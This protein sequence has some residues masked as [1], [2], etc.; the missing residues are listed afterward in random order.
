MSFFSGNAS[1]HAVCTSIIHHPM[2]D[3]SGVR[4][5]FDDASRLAV[6]AFPANLIK[7]MVLSR[8]AVPACYVLADH[9]RIYVGETGNIGRRLTDHAADPAKAFAREVFI[10]MGHEPAWLDK[11]AAIYLQHRLTVVADGAA[12]V[13]VVKGVSPQVLELPGYRRASYDRFFGDSLRLLYDAGCR[14]FQSNMAS[15]IR[16]Q[17]LNNPSAQWPEPDDCAPMEIGVIASPPIG[18]ELELTYSDLWAR[19]FP[20][21]EGFVVMAGSEMRSLINAS[22]TP[23]VHARRAELVAAGALA[24]IPGVHDRSRLKVAV[25]FPS[26]AIAAKVLAGAHVDSSKW[27]LPRYPQPIIIAA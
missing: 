10:I 25:R 20:A 15:Q 27:V 22:V 4:E 1:S 11:T 17:P 2:G 26:P 16:M 14:A 5:V 18:S 9:E 3:I 7:D 24:D 19:G 12:L 13:K 21:G 6:V 23:I 8:T